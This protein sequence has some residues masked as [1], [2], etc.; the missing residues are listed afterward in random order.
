MKVFKRI[1]ALLLVLALLLA[2]CPLAARSVS[3]QLS[4]GAM[5]GILCFFQ[6]SISQLHP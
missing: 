5:A 6:P 2:I 1:L 4:F 3:L